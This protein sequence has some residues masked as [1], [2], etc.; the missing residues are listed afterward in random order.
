LDS[1]IATDGIDWKRINAFHM[2]EFIGIDGKHPSSFCRFLKDKIFNTVDFQNVYYMN[3]MAS[4]PIRECHR[5][6]NLLERTPIDIAFI[7]IG[8]NGH[9]AFND[10]HIADFDDPEPVRIVELDPVALQQQVNDGHFKSLVE[11][12][13]KAITVTIP[14]MMKAPYAYI[15]VPDR[16]KAKIIKRTLKGPINEE[17]PGSILRKHCNAVLYLD[18]DSA[19]LLEL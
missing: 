6:S 18:N 9:I 15:V 19:S 17:C 11:V 7:G 13:S 5:Y 1:L 8:E 10:P 16:L 14:V 4:D 12:P 3:G 2:D